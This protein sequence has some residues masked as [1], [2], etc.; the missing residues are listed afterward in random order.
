MARVA[1]GQTPRK[2]PTALRSAIFHSGRTQ[3]DIAAS[4]GLSEGDFSRI[5]REKAVPRV[6]LASRIARELNTTVEGLWPDETR[7]A[8]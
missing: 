3:R 6:H 1:K 2:S 8:A 5:V 7:A 4:L